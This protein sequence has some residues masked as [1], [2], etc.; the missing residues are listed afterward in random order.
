LLQAG[1]NHKTQRQKQV[2]PDPLR[3]PADY[4]PDTDA[5]PAKHH[6]R[7]ERR[8][9]VRRHPQGGLLEDDS[10]SAGRWTT[11]VLSPHSLLVTAA[12]AAKK[13]EE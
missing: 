9:R 1:G 2:L 11:T 3:P 6:V 8:H 10:N 12:P 13:R 4:A 7:V 5:E